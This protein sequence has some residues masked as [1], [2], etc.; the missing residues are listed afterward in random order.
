ME[1]HNTKGRTLTIRALKF[2][3]QSAVSKPH[4]AE[5]K[6]EETDSMTIFIALNLIRE[7]QDPDLSF[8]FVCRAGIC[9]S[10][11]MMINGRPRLACRTLTKDF[12]DVITI[13]PLPAFKLIK[14]LSVNT[15]EWFAGMTKRVESWVHSNEKVDISKLEKPIEPQEAQDVFELDRCIECGCCIASCATKLMR[16]DFIGGAGMNRVVRFMIDSHDQRTDEDFYEL[17]GNDDGVFG[18]MSLIACHDTC[19]KNLPLQSKIAYLR[20]KMVSVGR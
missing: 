14:D 17:V 19:P 6:L 11:S 9:G 7:K 8:D 20:R 5:Y 10:C 1:N 16:E 3:P 15:G 2:D 18:C 13:M 4:F 12:P